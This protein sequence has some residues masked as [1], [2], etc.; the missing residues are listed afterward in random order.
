MAS[1]PVFGLAKAYAFGSGID[2]TPTVL[3]ITAC[4]VWLNVFQATSGS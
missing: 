2:G 3:P 1:A 4:G